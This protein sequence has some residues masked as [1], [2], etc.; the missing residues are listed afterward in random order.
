MPEL[1]PSVLGK[2]WK[3][4]GPTSVPSP[5][6]LKDGTEVSEAV[7]RIV[8]GRG[9]VN[10]STWLDAPIRAYLPKDGAFPRLAE[11]AGRI[12]SAV[13]R[14]ERIAL[15][16]DYDVDGATSVAQMSR[17]ISAASGVQPRTYIPDRAAEGYG[18]NKGAMDKL[19]AEGIRLLVVQDSG[20]TALEVLGYAVTL[21][22][23]VVIIDHHEPREDGALPPAIVVNPKLVDT[24]PLGMDYL[25]TAGLTMLVLIECNKQ[26]REAGMFRPSPNT[27][28][29]EDE[30]SGDNRPPEPD[31]R[32]LLGLVALGTVADVVPLVGL[33]R[34][35][36]RHGLAYAEDNPGLQA[37]MEATERHEPSAYNCGF[38]WGPCINAGGRL[39]NTERG[40]RL[41][42]SDDED[43]CRRL[44]MELRAVND[45]RKLVQSSIMDQ[46]LADIERQ[47]GAGT[48]DSVLV[49]HLPEAHQGVIGVVAGKIKELLD[50]SVLVIGQGG[51]GSARG[52]MGFN[53]GSEFLR[54][55]EDGVLIKG[56]GHAAAAG[57][58]IDPARIPELRLRLSA[59]SQGIRR[60]PLK[61]EMVAEAGSVPMHVVRSLL[62]LA[63]VGMGNP[64]AVVLLTGGTLRNVQRIK[65]R[66]VK[67]LL[68]GEDG[69]KVTIMEWGGVDTSLGKAMLAGEGQRLDLLCKLKV[70]TYAGTDYVEASPVDMRFLGSLFHSP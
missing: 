25:C 24:L 4:P 27:D 38:I 70:G 19:A 58:T 21:G 15:Y 65:G 42:S 8:L 20:T 60:E 48:P 67:A 53:I 41:L 49:I 68:V 43:E 13:Q 1:L 26:A 56:G 39:G 37:L 3:L 51:K 28:G 52:V 47:G 62:L 7:L 36:V 6:V 14:E 64:N 63:P 9:V 66:H 29:D 10:P 54:A 69:K 2:E 33:N 35:Y 5:V 11:A 61:V 44:A 59:A 30:F 45:E 16:G 18:P 55:Y 57:L 40:A 12:I 31:L 50:R 17:W 34:A 46:A 32:R 22:M 23:D